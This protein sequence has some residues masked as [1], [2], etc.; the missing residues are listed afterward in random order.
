MQHLGLSYHS[1]FCFLNQTTHCCAEM[2]STG[3]PL[4]LV[5]PSLSELYLGQLNCHC[6]GF[7]LVGSTHTEL[8]LRQPT[9][10]MREL[11]TEL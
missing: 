5:L 6:H 11:P 8:E 4:P 2:T 7:P 1:S 9:Y 3:S 10:S